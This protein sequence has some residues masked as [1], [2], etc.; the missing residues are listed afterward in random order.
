[1][2]FHCKLQLSCFISL[3]LSQARQQ[4]FSQT[5]ERTGAGGR[6]QRELLVCEFVCI[7]VCVCVCGCLKR[8]IWQSRRKEKIDARTH[9]RGGVRVC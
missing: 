3:I 1:M 9:L 8:M 2:F 4:T 5:I 7:C 6:P